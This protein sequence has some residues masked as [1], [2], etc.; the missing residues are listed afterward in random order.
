MIEL[1]ITISL[2]PWRRRAA[3]GEETIDQGDQPDVVARVGEH[4]DAGETTTGLGF[5]GPG[6]KE[7]DAWGSG[8]DDRTTKGAHQ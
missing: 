4:L 6:P 7:A 3:P 8:P 1:R 5:T 2:D